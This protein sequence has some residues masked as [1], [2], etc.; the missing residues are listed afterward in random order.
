M[1]RIS[2][3]T[4]SNSVSLGSRPF[5]DVP[6]T[7]GTRIG[8]AS[9]RLITL[10]LITP[11]R[12]PASDAS[13]RAPAVPAARRELEVPPALGVLIANAAAPAT[14][15]RGHPRARVARPVAAPERAEPV[16]VCHAGRRVRDDGVRLFPLASST[17]ATSKLPLSPVSTNAS[18]FGPRLARA[19]GDASPR[20]ASSR[21]NR[22][23]PSFASV[24]SAV[25]RRSCSRSPRRVTPR[26]TRGAGRVAPRASDDTSPSRA[27]RRT[28]PPRRRARNASHGG[29]RRRARRGSAPGPRRGCRRGRLCGLC[30]LCVHIVHIVHTRRARA[31]TPRGRRPGRRRAAS[32]NHRVRPSPASGKNRDG[33]FCVKAALS[34][35]PRPS[36]ALLPARSLT[37][38]RSV[39]P[40]TTCIRSTPRFA[41]RPAPRSSASKNFGNASPDATAST[42]PSS[43]PASASPRAAY[44]SRRRA[45]RGTSASTEAP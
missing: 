31:R 8:A 28:P 33:G 29:A 17:A 23:D 11:I 15:P 2:S 32:R 5:I 27:P 7:F 3:R 40:D 30:G 43:G 13:A 26:T 9:F 6:A 37:A 16:Q 21:P 25:R 34:S 44:I 20:V 10:I 14:G 19:N 45:P 22:A 39:R 41:A 42:S 12:R 18:P 38:A 1:A 24:S 4:S 36:I 35:S